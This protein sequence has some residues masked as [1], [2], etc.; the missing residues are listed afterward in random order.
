VSATTG[1]RD[2]PACAGV[3]PR[4]SRVPGHMRPAAWA[5]AKIRLGAPGR[6]GNALLSYILAVLAG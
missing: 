5:S 2:V 1:I 3:S 6:E 4:L